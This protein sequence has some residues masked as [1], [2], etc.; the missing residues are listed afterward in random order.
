MK[1][2]IPLIFVILLLL[3]FGYF[4]LP[5]LVDKETVQIRSDMQE[6]QQKV[7]KIEEFIQG[8]EDA[9]KSTQLTPDADLQK[10]IRTVNAFASR[11]AVL[12]DTRKKDVSDIDKKL[13]EQQETQKTVLST[14]TERIDSM[15]KETKSS[16]QKIE[17]DAAMANI[18]VHILKAR[19]DLL[20]K[21]IGTAKAE[22]LLISEALEKIKNSASEHNRKMIEELQRILMSAKNEV[23]SDLPAATNKIDLLWHEMGKLLKKS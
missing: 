16:T 21:N 10:V 8:E 19:E 9:R 20:Y 14:Q 12:E 7:Q 11:V 18:R 13:K 1:T 17:F 6:L 23:D 3:A 22:F 15:N 5:I 2:V 4:G